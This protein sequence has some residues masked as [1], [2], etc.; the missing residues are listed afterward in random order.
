MRKRIKRTA[1][2]NR[3]RRYF[4]ELFSYGSVG[5]VNGIIACSD[6]PIS[7]FFNG[8]PLLYCSR[9]TNKSKIGA[10]LESMA[11]TEVVME[12]K[13]NSGLKMHINKYTATV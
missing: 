7:S 13:V 6:I 11:S 8:V 5:A 4:V 12:T 9:I 1:A 3:V 2:S 10:I